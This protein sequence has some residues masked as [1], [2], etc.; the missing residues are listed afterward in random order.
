MTPTTTSLVDLIR[1]GIE[2]WLTAGTIVANRVDA[3]ETLEEIAAECACDFV[4]VGIL[5]QFERIGRKQ[6]L[7]RILVSDFPAVK[8]LSIMPISEQ[9][10]LLDGHVDLV[11]KTATGADVLK[12]RV[13]DLTRRQV[14]Q[15]FANGS[16]RD[17]G[18]QRAWLEE[19][20]KVVQAKPSWSIRGKTVVF[21]AP[22]TLS[23][24]DILA[25]AS[26]L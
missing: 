23:R 9:A 10:R 22:C 5:S 13:R 25:I 26:Q 21:Y 3:G 4:T 12:T 11:I 17:P 14:R 6:I 7:P 16:V 15:V 18:A 8:Q 1:Q 19:N 20:F 2:A 24:Q